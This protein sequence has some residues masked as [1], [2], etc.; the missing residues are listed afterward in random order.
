MR[1]GTTMFLKIALFVIGFPILALCVAG[2]PWMAGE[3]VEVHPEWDLWRYP[4]LA[5]MYASA[6]AYF[7]ALFQAYRLLTYIDRD[8]AFS[9]LSVS[10]LRKIR[11]CA[12]I[13]SFLYTALM[14]FIYI[15]AEVDDAPG[16]I[17]LGMVIIFASA[18]IAV[19]AAVL[20]T[21]LRSVI[22]IKT[23]NDLT[24]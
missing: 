4:V 22:D 16:L 5:G 11:N 15:M 7:A 10:A 21:L 24:V 19:F 13:I 18:V 9:D 3:L 1:N 8:E 14:P 17:V 2:L 6:V 23:E 20:Q 12:V